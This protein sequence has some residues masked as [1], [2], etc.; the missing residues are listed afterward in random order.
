[1]TDPELLARAL[2]GDRT[3]ARQLY[4]AHAPRVFGLVFRLTGDEMLA[5]DLTQDTFV[6]AFAR[7]GTFRG[8]AAFSTW[9][10][11]IA[12]SITSNALRSR[13]RR[14]ARHVELHEAEHLSGNDV[15]VDP[16]LR[17]S[18]ARALDELPETYRTVVIMHD[19][20]GYTHNQIAA[21]LGVAEGTCKSRL[22]IAHGMLRKS[23]ARLE[24]DV[25]A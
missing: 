21:V 24:G 2:A 15:A 5:R 12:V 6:R 20:E 22:S 13:R 19:L 10:H 1:M 16:I 23:L 18:L 9:L 17:A 25:D 7:L 4:D 14:D 3:A 11:R 8:E